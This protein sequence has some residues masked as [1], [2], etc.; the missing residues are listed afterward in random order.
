MHELLTLGGHLPNIAIIFDIFGELPIGFCHNLTVAKNA[1][2]IIICHIG[3]LKVWTSSTIIWEIRGISDSFFPNY[4]RSC[5][6]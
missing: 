3:S 2:K 4:R 6:S 1:L 5:P